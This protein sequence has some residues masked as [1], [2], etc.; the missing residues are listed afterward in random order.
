MRRFAILLALTANLALADGI[1]KE[2]AVARLKGS[3]PIEVAEGFFSLAYVENRG[4]AWGMFQGN[5]WPLAAFG[6]V[7]LAFLVWKRRQI[8]GDGKLPILFSG[9][10]YAGILGNMLDRIVRGFVVDMFDFHW[11]ASHFPCFNLA[12]AYIT[13]AA[14]YLAAGSFFGSGKDT[15]K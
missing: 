1:V 7:A 11:G 9:M 8:F 6:A 12:D 2:W 10:L 4:C 5:V 3:S 15:R 13:L 14:A